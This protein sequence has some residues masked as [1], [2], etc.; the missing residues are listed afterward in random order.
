M[1]NWLL[2]STPQLRDSGMLIIRIG[3]GLIFV[4]HGFL[5]ILGGTQTWIWLG[6]MMHMNVPWP[7]VW[8][9][10]A[11][12]SEFLGGF[13]LAIG[14]GTRIAAYFISNVMIFAFIH[15]RVHGDSYM[16]YSYP[17]T[18]LTVMI[19]FLIAGGGYYSVDAIIL[20][21]GQRH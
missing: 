8:G 12:A 14:F 4:G 18:M 6:Q 13:C 2:G 1:K 15:H 5:K 10:A 7:M 11:T 20:R 3:V 19:G 16:H 21:R 17:L 9:L